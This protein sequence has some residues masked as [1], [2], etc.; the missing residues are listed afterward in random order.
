MLYTMTKATTTMMMLVAEYFCVKEL[1]FGAYSSG[2]ALGGDSWEK[3]EKEEEEEEEEG[4]LARRRRRSKEG[5]P[6]SLSAPTP[7]VVSAQD[8]NSER[9]SQ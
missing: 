9:Q 3:E 8:T 2:W 1:C 4:H 5:E 7:A 6:K